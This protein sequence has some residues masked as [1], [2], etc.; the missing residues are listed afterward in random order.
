M[1]WDDIERELANQA[2]KTTYSVDTDKLWDNVS[3]HIPQEKKRDRFIL[4][5]I[6]IGA[7]IAGLVT[8]QSILS[9]TKGNSNTLSAIDSLHRLEVLVDQYSH[10]DEHIDLNKTDIKKAESPQVKISKTSITDLV[11]NKNSR[12]NNIIN[13]RESDPA[14]S[15]QSNSS[16]QSNI[17]RDKE[18]TSL[19]EVAASYIQS[20][21]YSKSIALTIGEMEDHKEDKNTAYAES[22]R[23]VES[24]SLLEV[25]LIDEIYN[26]LVNLRAPHS[27]SFDIVKLDNKLKPQFYSEAAGSVAIGHG[28]LSLR[29]DDW[30]DSYQYRLHAES[31]LPS[32]AGR[33]HLGLTFNDKW[34]FQ[35][36]VSFQQ[37]YKRSISEINTTQDVTL[38]DAVI[39][40]II[41]ANG[42]RFITGSAVVQEITTSDVSRISYIRMFEVPI[43]V[44]YTLRTQQVYW[45]ISFGVSYSLGQSR[46]GYIHPSDNIEYDT[47]TDELDWYNIGGLWSTQ[48]S[49]GLRIPLSNK[50]DLLSR[51][52]Y[53][54]YLTDQALPSYGIREDLSHWQIELGARFNF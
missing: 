14:L 40:Q 3:P 22:K 52:R 11:S 30:A 15:K 45:D 12:K 6:F 34:S 4:F 21:P 9:T 16:L 32:Y 1:N 35:T 38:D 33:I 36:G 54:Y 42:S 47:S 20:T 7:C 5:W 23:S 44:I 10:V 53:K 39:Q 48:A 28:G 49:A 27:A 29:S 2:N 41:D 25:L 17:I 19:D 37:L 24:L 43:D 51:G 46:S 26:K 13:E 8:S 18:H 31:A 50:I